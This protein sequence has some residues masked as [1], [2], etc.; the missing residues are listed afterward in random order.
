M[1]KCAK[2]HKDSPSDKKL[3]SL[4]RARLNFR[5]RRFLCTTLNRNLTQASNFGGTFDQVFLWNF[6]WNFTKNASPLFLCYG[7]KKS[8]MTK[9]SNQGARALKTALLLVSWET[10]EQKRRPR[11]AEISSFPTRDHSLKSAQRS[12]S[13]EEKPWVPAGGPTPPCGRSTLHFVCSDGA[14]AVVHCPGKP[15]STGPKWKGVLSLEFLRTQQWGLGLDF[16]SRR[17]TRFF[18]IFNADHTCSWEARCN[19]KLGEGLAGRGWNHI[20]CP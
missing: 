17:P 3:N 19:K 18:I 2:F 6:L 11:F 13:L 10:L 1:N 9:N 7:V 4:S 5:R 15:A 14:F 20:Y 12:K 16:K 8:K